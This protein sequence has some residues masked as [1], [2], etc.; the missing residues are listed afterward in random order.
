MAYAVGHRTPSLHK[1]DTTR[2]PWADVAPDAFI[3]TPA[4]WDDAR[5]RMELIVQRIL[6]DQV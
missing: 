1:D 4:D 3:P 2:I 5:K 6:V